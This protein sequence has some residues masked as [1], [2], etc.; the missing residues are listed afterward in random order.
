[1]DTTLAIL[2]RVRDIRRR[3]ALARTLQA[4]H[5]VRDAEATVNASL[6]SIRTQTDF[7]HQRARLLDAAPQDQ[8]LSVDMLAI[9][10][11][12]QARLR[13]IVAN[14]QTTLQE[15]RQSLQ[16]GQTQLQEARTAF[17]R[18][19]AARSRIQH[20]AERANAQSAARA[21]LRAEDQ[22]DDHNALAYARALSLADAEEPP[23]T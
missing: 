15:Q 4:A 7:R 11:Y 2:R 18:A 21:E 1:M 3:K 19:E 8:A 14:V 22:L 17:G 23:A 13:H 10:H 12:E 16:S 20:L 9:A 5:V 6:Q